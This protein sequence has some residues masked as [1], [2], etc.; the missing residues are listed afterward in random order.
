M[1]GQTHTCSMCV[2]GRVGT[3]VRSAPEGSRNRVTPAKYKYTSVGTVVESNV[4]GAWVWVSLGESGI[5]L[6][7]TSA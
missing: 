4:G 6:R 5:A 2:F 3:S 1:P 7:I